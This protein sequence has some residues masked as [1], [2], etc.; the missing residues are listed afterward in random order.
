MESHYAARD[1]RIRPIFLPHGGQAAAGNACVS[2]AQGH[3]LAR[4]DA[5]DVVMP[6]RFERQYALLAKHPEIT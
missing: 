4:M 2:A 3:W 1:A 6:G 5:D